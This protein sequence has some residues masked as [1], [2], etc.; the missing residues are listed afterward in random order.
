MTALAIVFVLMFVA[1][2]GV[3]AQTFTVLHN[4]TG[5]QD[6][7]SPSGGV[8][9]DQAGTLYGTAF[10]GGAGYGT[11]FKLSH[12][13][14]GWI[15]TPL[16]VFQGGNDG[17]GPVARVVLGPDN[18][19]YGTTQNGGSGESGTVFN[20]KPPVTACKTALCPWTKTVVHSFTGLD[21]AGPGFADLVFNQ[22]GNVYGTTDSGGSSGGGYGG[23][24][25]YELMP[26]NGS[27]TESVLYS[28]I[29][30]I[31]FPQGVIFDK[32][33]YPYGTTS[34]SY[35]GWLPTVFQLTPSGSGWLDNILYQFKDWSYGQLGGLVFDETGNLYGSTSAGGPGGEG[36]VYELTPTQG[37]WT[38]SLV[39]AFT[40]SGGSYYHGLIIDSAGNLYGT[41]EGGGADMGGRVFKLTR[42]GGGWTET[43]LHVFCVNGP[44]CSDG[45]SP[46]GNIM[47]D[48]HGNLY[49]TTAFGGTYDNGVVWEITP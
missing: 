21:G 4:F 22:A 16:Y 6:G 1:T 5:G 31:Q 28:F 42:S 35:Q 38:Y 48:A 32:A 15:F 29:P 45:A 44:P 19:L 41:T 26:F 24:A 34:G 14:S 43:D 37:G 11:V 18:S 23:G 46:R 40:G 33:S 25:V 7:A 20:L 49:G 10:Q 27:W 3:Q 47:F 39:Y 30:P 13:G 17:Y 9:I 12:K 2:Q 8:T 36:I